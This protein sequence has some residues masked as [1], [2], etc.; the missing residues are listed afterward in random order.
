MGSVF[1]LNRFIHSTTHRHINQPFLV[2]RAGMATV[3]NVAA[4]GYD[5]SF[6]SLVKEKRAQCFLRRGGGAGIA[7]ALGS[8]PERGIC[9]DDADV[10]RRKQAFGENTYPKAKKKSFFSHVRDALSDVLLIALLVCAAVALGFGIEEHRIKDVVYDSL[11]IFITVLLVS[12]VA[13]VISHIKA[14]FDERWVRESANIAIT[15]GRAGR[16]QDVSV[17]DIVVGDVVILKTGHAIPADGVFLKGHGL[18]VDESSIT[19]DPRPVRIDAEKNPLPSLGR[20]GRAW[21]R[22][23]GRYRRRHRHHLG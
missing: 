17:F 4:D 22:L 2:R 5:E 12:G 10:R 13:A 23:D 7:A 19:C 16:R 14:K 8:H 20:E 18:Q 6:K 1:P 9:G 3:I 11:G 15:V 21:P